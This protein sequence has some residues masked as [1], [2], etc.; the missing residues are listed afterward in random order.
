MC[1]S[2]SAMNRAGSTTTRSLVGSWWHVRLRPAANTAASRARA[3]A[4][5]RRHPRRRSRCIARTQ[6]RPTLLQPSRQRPA[7]G[8]KTLLGCAMASGRA[9]DPRPCPSRAR[10]RRASFLPATPSALSLPTA[11]AT[12]HL[13]RPWTAGFS[14]N[15][16]YLALDTG[17]LHPPCWLPCASRAQ[18]PTPTREPTSRQ[19]TSPRL[20]RASCATTTWLMRAWTQWRSAR[21]EQARK[22]APCSTGGGTTCA[23]ARAPIAS[24][25]PHES[26]SSAPKTCSLLTACSCPSWMSRKFT[27]PSAASTSSA[28]SWSS[29]APSGWM[30]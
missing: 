29:F 15:E 28:T 26:S 17:V 18:L 2:Y 20:P 22:L 13:A 4:P 24:R 11:V 19:A 16:S 12:R 23:T 1:M 8:A 5:S 10:S 6:P 7:S 21:G 30:G 27:G 3:P 25:K 9:A 14:P